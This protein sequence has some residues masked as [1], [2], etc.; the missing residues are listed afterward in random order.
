MLLPLWSKYYGFLKAVKWQ[1]ERDSATSISQVAE[2]F[3]QIK[4]SKFSFSALS[5]S[6]QAE[7]HDEKY[8]IHAT[9]LFY[10]FSSINV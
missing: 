5:Q 2:N 7:K 6:V 3:K 4:N 8:P 10:P 9:L 1:L